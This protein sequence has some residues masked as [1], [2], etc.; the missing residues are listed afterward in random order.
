MVF[1]GD[2]DFSGTEADS[3]AVSAEPISEEEAVIGGRGI[4]S[5]RTGPYPSVAKPCASSVPLGPGTVRY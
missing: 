1:T 4:S 3:A 2:C 5:G